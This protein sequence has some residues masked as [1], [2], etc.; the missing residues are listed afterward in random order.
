MSKIEGD[1]GPKEGRGSKA[2][3]SGIRETG[4]L[5]NNEASYD[6]SK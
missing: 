6:L 4:A 5:I 1:P 3:S 2:N